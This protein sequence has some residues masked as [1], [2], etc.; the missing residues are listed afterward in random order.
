MKRICKICKSDLEA[1]D[2]WNC[3]GE[4]Y[5]EDFHDCGEDCCCCLNPEPGR[6]PE[7]HGKGVL[8]ECPNEKKHPQFN[9]EVKR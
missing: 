6:C 2:C 1:V 8:W 3:G 7:C 4:G 5:S 9:Q